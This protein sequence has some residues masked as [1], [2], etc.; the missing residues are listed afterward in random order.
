MSRPVAGSF[1]PSC[2]TDVRIG[3]DVGGTFTDFVAWHPQRGW[4]RLK[5]PTSRPDPAQGILDG[6]KSLLGQPAPGWDLGHGTT[7][8][9]NTALERSGARLA[10]ITTQGFGDI[11]SLGRGQ[12]QDLYAIQS[13]NRPTRVA[14]EDCF[15]VPE[16]LNAQ[17]E[18]LTPLDQERLETTALEIQQR[19]ITQ[20]AVCLL[21]SYLNPANVLPR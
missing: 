21:F 7:I 18:V 5:Q 11:L 1:R 8:A 19:G 12:R 17:G 20:V 4:L 15:E 9:T 14:P 16:R 10:L 3:V 13:A 2:S 6:L